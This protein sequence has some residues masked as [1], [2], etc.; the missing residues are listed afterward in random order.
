[1][2]KNNFNRY[3]NKWLIVGVP[4]FIKPECLWFYQGK[5]EFLD[6]EGIIL[7]GGGKEIYITYDRIRQIST[8]GSS[9]ASGK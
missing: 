6:D 3:K 5:L 1:M 7:K 8:S 9:E 2:N 4:H